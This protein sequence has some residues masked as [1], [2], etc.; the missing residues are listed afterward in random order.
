MTY[1]PAT[2]K[3]VNLGMPMP[4]GDK[5]LPKG[6]KEG[7]GVIDYTP[8]CIRKVVRRKLVHGSDWPILPIPLRRIG[9]KKAAGL[10]FSEGNGLQ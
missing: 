9:W 7:E 6:A 1:D 5:R 8:K 3:A 10:L 2:G 4:L